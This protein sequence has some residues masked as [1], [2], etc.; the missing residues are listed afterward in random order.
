MGNSE[1]NM[2]RLQWDWDLEPLINVALS[3]L[4]FVQRASEILI[5]HLHKRL[6]YQTQL[7]HVDFVSQSAFSQM[8]L[9]FLT[10]ECNVFIWTR[11][12]DCLYLSLACLLPLRGGGASWKS[13]IWAGGKGPWSCQEPLVKKL[14]TV[15][16]WCV[17]AVEENAWKQDIHF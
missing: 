11:R 15:F 8:S 3:I 2:K 5:H 10:K 1:E 12:A 13:N 4:I 7:P 9:Y 14:Q 16:C 17:T 6:Q